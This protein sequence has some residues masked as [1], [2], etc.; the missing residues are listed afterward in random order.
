MRTL[1]VDAFSRRDNPE[2]VYWSIENELQAQTIEMISVLAAEKRIKEPRQV[3]RPGGPQKKAAPKGRQTQGLAA[4]TLA[5]AEWAER[6][7]GAGGDARFILAPDGPKR[8]KNLPG[9]ESRA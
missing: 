8:L 3:P 1:P 6:N 9:G 5:M 2:D 4:A 7:G